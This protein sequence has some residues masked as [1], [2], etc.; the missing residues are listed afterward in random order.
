MG[1]ENRKSGK[2][3]VGGVHFVRVRLSSESIKL[4]CED[5]DRDIEEGVVISSSVATI[6]RQ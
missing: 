5:R 6:Y 3:C 4:D 1:I 2:L